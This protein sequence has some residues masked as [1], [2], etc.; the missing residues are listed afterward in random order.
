[1][2]NKLAKLFTD[3]PDYNKK[4][5]K[6]LET[7]YSNGWVLRATG[8]ELNIDHKTVKSILDAIQTADTYK[9]FMSKVEDTVQSFADG[10]FSHTIFQRYE[11]TLADLD[12]KIKSAMAKEDE[13]LV[14][15]YY[16]L[17]ISVLKDQ[18][19]A[20]LTHHTNENKSTAITN[21]IQSLQ[22]EAWDEY[23]EKIN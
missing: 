22:D 4:M 11:T 15:Q 13:R 9:I 19:R 1:M 5:W 2:N 16:K 12:K 7:C 8:R 14:I 6:F 10:D 23:G 18:L 20:S 21:A 3:E 17:K